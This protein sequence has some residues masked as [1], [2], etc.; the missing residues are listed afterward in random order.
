MLQYLLV[1][2]CVGVAR[3][4]GGGMGLVYVTC[5]TREKSISSPKRVQ[6]NGIT[7]S[8]HPYR[9]YQTMIDVELK[10]ALLGSIRGFWVNYICL[11]GD[12]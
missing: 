5:T 11:G 8:S 9:R 3:G 10:L 2:R 6:H 1:I 12:S 7:I 4:R